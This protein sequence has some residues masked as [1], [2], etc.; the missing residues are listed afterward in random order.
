MATVALNV[1]SRT[2][3]RKGAARELRRN[4]FV[5]GVIYGSGN[6]AVSIKVDKKT[7]EKISMR[8]HTNAIFD[9][10]IEDSGEKTL[11]MIKE[12]QRAPLSA[13][14]LHVDFLKITMDHVVDIELPVVLVNPENIKKAGGIIQQMVNEIRA[15]CMPTSIPEKVEIDLSGYKPGDSVY[16]KNLVLPEGVT[17]T[18]DPIEVIVTIIATKSGKS[19]DE[20]EESAE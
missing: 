8:G 5:P 10:N 1:Q 3:T 16:V 2:E 6:P 13:K 15:Q 11:A 4:G 20:G 19:S 12:I 14:L 7:L 18:S 9:I 17:A